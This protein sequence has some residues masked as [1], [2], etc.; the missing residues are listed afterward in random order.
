MGDVNQY[1]RPGR[2]TISK[3]EQATGSLVRGTLL[4]NLYPVTSPNSNFAQISLEY[5]DPESGQQKKVDE[6]DYIYPAHGQDI[7]T[8]VGT[9]ILAVGDEAGRL[10]LVSPPPI[11]VEGITPNGCPAPTSSNIPSYCTLQQTITVTTEQIISVETPS[12]SGQYQ[13]TYNGHIS[14]VIPWDK[15]FASGNWV[16]YFP[17]WI[18]FVNEI[19]GNINAG[20]T[21]KYNPSGNLD[22]NA[23]L[24]GVL[25]SDLL[26][27]DDNV[28]ESQIVVV[29]NRVP[30]VVSIRVANYDQGRII[31]PGDFI[32]AAKHCNQWVVMY[33]SCQNAP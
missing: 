15:N 2:L 8:P 33:V 14:T 9:Q 21:I 18:S 17:G 3:K 26:D 1:R 19:T 30:N 32:K 10:V 27:A 31:L 24:T 20:L 25:A 4:E 22:F 23:L 7:V 6:F 13:L 11:Y 29:G 16:S 5:T 12:A 28:L